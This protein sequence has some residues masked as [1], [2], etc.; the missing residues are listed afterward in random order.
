MEDH[1]A[2]PNQSSMTE[3][4]LN[5]WLSSGWQLLEN[6][7]L[8]QRVQSF[9]E[10]GEISK[11]LQDKLQR[12]RLHRER[13]QACLQ[14][15]PIS[16]EAFF[17][18]VSLSNSA[19]E[20]AAM[21]TECEYR[22]LN[23]IPM[24][25]ILS[26]GLANEPNAA[27][28]AK[29]LESYFQWFK[30]LRRW[31]IGEVLLVHPNPENRG[32]SIEAL[33]VLGS[34]L[35]KL[36]NLNALMIVL[37][38]VCSKYIMSQEKAWRFVSLRCCQRFR[39][40]ADLMSPCED[41]LKYRDLLRR[42]Q[43][44][45]P[46]LGLFLLDLARVHQADT[47]QQKTPLSPADDLN[48]SQFTKYKTISELIRSFTHCLEVHRNP[49]RL[50]EPTKSGLVPSKEDLRRLSGTL[51]TLDTQNKAFPLAHFFAH[52]F[53]TGAEFDV[54]AASQLTSLDFTYLESCLPRQIH[55][56][57]QLVVV[58]PQQQNILFLILRGRIDVVRSNCHPIQL[59]AG[60]CFGASSTSSSLS[61]SFSS[62]LSA[63]PTLPP[64]PTFPSSLAPSSSSSSL[65]FSSIS[66]SA[67]SLSLS[68]TTS[69]SSSSLSEESTESFE[70]S[71]LL[72][73]ANSEVAVM[74]NDNI[75]SLVTAHPS[76]MSFQQRLWRSILVSYLSFFEQR[77]DQ[78]ALS[79]PKSPSQLPQWASAP[80][81]SSSAAAASP[82]QLRKTTNG[83]QPTP[84]TPSS[85]F[86]SP[87]PFD[88]S[89]PLHTSSC[90]SLFKLHGMDHN[91]LQQLL[92]VSEKKTL[93]E[94]DIL[95]K[96]GTIPQSIYI[97]VSG[98]FSTSSN[99]GEISFSLEAIS[100]IHKGFFDGTPSPFSVAVT[101]ASSEVLEIKQHRLNKLCSLHPQLISK[102]YVFALE[103]S[104][105]LYFSELTLAKSSV[106]P[107]SLKI[108]NCPFQH[109]RQLLL[110]LLHGADSPSTSEHKHSSRA[111]KTLTQKPSTTSQMTRAPPHP[112]TSTSSS[113]T[114]TS[115]Q[116]RGYMATKIESKLKS[117]LASLQKAATIEKPRKPET[118]TR[119]IATLTDMKPYIVMEKKN[120]RLLK[121]FVLSAHLFSR[122][123]LDFLDF[124]LQFYVD[125][126]SGRRAE[127]GSANKFRVLE[128]LLQWLALRPLDFVTGTATAEENPLRQQLSSFLLRTT[129]A[130]NASEAPN[131]M[132]L[133]YCMSIQRLLSCL[134]VKPSD[135]SSRAAASLSASALQNTLFTQ[136]NYVR[137]S[138]SA[139]CPWKSSFGITFDDLDLTACARALSV[140]EHS[141][142][143]Q[144]SPQDFLGSMKEKGSLNSILE[145]RKNL[146]RWVVSSIVVSPTTSQRASLISK[147]MF[148]GKALLGLNNFNS[149]AS[150]ILALT[151]RD[152][153][154][155]TKTWELVDMNCR[156]AWDEIS[157]IID[158]QHNYKIYYKRLR[159]ILSQ[160][161]SFVP[162]LEHIS[163]NFSSLEGRIR[164]GVAP[165]DSSDSNL[166]PSKQT[167]IDVV[168]FE[169]LGGLAEIVERAQSSSYH[170]ADLDPKV[171]FCMLNL[172]PL[173]DTVIIHQ[174]SVSRLATE[175]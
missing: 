149:L 71:H 143:S 128:L 72:C 39:R 93:R 153:R 80:L 90:T 164:D 95:Y 25:A 18:S 132:I 174:E 54:L 166:H 175:K 159:Q 12:L 101:S 16:V 52:P 34:H 146:T 51:G 97:G 37:S 19:R 48:S 165:L 27:A 152:V 43:V 151:E 75:E 115:A 123:T 26:Y 155:L 46:Y 62:S 96:K 36:K 14:S 156:K 129:T 91:A 157:W 108:H 142:I 145:F 136:L 20:L 100:L 139:P 83:Q 85:P 173:F 141:L 98:T 50:P 70:H 30:G 1:D 135:C 67:S 28:A 81:L 79:L 7:E 3:W 21:I 170:F 77:L 22:L 69:S 42:G 31:L 45:I 172:T 162:M 121:G 73:V 66:S 111:S 5:S 60:A 57:G 6:D 61:S 84:F 117:A 114:H 65:S 171:V 158:K 144:L 150:I 74:S 122:S 134:A 9:S 59:A 102:L 110:T 58:D 32:K 94:G 154:R 4:I 44:A 126:G 35:K 131:R 112:S 10:R 23:T 40:L 68:L 116:Q 140:I 49:C 82:D 88:L 147:F 86:A 104:A 148:L 13:R 63:F 24:S 107:A 120:D 87:F 130:E 17:K 41:F 119:A 53:I 137:T 56:A 125:S 8:Y 138:P 47:A 103:S 64:F 55:H 167:P 127:P 89:D 76:S 15:G 168:R 29:E 124:L 161:G 118:T 2:R 106:V 109:H 105:C 11:P 133:H 169:Q 78:P 99:S 92:E 113:E 38:A 163:H 160:G 33:I